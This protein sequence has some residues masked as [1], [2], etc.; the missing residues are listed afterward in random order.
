MGSFVA[1]AAVPLVLFRLL[2]TAQ[3]TALMLLVSMALL[4]ALGAMAARLG[5]APLLRPTLR[6]GAFG[7]LAMGATMGIGRLF[8][9]AVA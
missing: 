1:G 2:P 8:G 5:G 4:M 3:R 7:L 6:V 9:V